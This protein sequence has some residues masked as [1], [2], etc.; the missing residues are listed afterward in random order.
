MTTHYFEVTEIKIESELQH[1]LADVDRP[2]LPPSL[3]KRVRFARLLEKDEKGP[4][5]WRIVSAK[6][7]NNQLSPVSPRASTQ[8][9][10]DRE[11]PTENPNH[12]L[13][14]I[15]AV[16]C[17]SSSHI[18]LTLQWPSPLASQNITSPHL[19]TDPSTLPL[20]E[21]VCRPS[22]SANSHSSPSSAHPSPLSGPGSRTTV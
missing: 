2:S 18:T 6:L 8:R 19:P 5:L 14:S 11:S 10:R 21:L 1:A 22:C 4:S 20:T 9:Q 12:Q 7:L 16:L 17:S 3:L 15:L 13:H